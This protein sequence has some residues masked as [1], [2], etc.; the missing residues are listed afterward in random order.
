MTLAQRTSSPSSELSILGTLEPRYATP[1]LRDDLWTNPDASYGYD[2]IR[3]AK[4]IDHP[5]DPWQEG[6]VIR[7]GEYLDDNETLRFLFVLLIVARQ[8]GKTEVVAILILYWMFVERQ[9]LI[10]GASG[11]RDRAME[12]WEKAVEIAEN[13]E[14]LAPYL[15]FKP[16]GTIKDAQRQL[17]R[18]YFKTADGCE[19]R[20]AAKTRKTGRGATLNRLILDEL[21][22]HTDWRTYNASTP[23]LLIPDNSQGFFMSNAGVKDSVVLNALRKAAL[24]FIRT[25][26]GDD[27][28]GLIEW[29][30]DE[31]ASVT[32]R[33]AWADANPNL[34]YRTPVKKIAARARTA[35]AEGGELEAGFRN[36]YL[37]QFLDSFNGAIDSDAWRDG[38]VEGDLSHPD[39]ERVAAIEVSKDRRHV[40]LMAGARIADARIR[41]ETKMVWTGDDAINDMRRDLSGQL[42]GRFRAFGWIPGGPT[43]T[44]STDMKPRPGVWPPVGVTP[45]EIP[46]TEFADICMEFSE[47]VDAGQ[48]IH[49]SPDD[50][51]L[52]AQV[53][54]AVKRKIGDKWG[55]D[56]PEGTK[57]YVDGVVGA[58]IVVH[59]IRNLPPTPKIT[60]THA[61]RGVN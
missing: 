39:L 21:R 31:N 24:K 26:E 29:S 6:F 10:L 13:T 27:S 35:A 25:G 7:A 32:N 46:V 42:R 56:R 11:D 53:T 60:K 2:V 18:T 28:F 40:T 50:D 5:L 33:Q 15:R 19:Y 47:Q 45:H 36:E 23:A 30:A 34:G 37:C 17:A 61:L 38:F 3:F 49:S 8:S 54:G 4:W 44:I 14:V 55:F 16:D 43:A 9:P 41:V 22:E 57:G 12:S 51:M 59:L 48:V 52:T 58:A 1:P 20:I